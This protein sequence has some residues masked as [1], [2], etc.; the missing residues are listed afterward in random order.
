MRVSK[1]LYVADTKVCEL[2][3]T[4]CER[5]IPFQHAGV[6]E[7]VFLGTASSDQH[8][9]GVPGFP[10]KNRVVVVD[11][12]VPDIIL[13]VAEEEGISL[14]VVGLD[15]GEERSYLKSILKK[16]IDTSP[17]PLLIVSEKEGQGE[18]GLFDH[19]IFAT[20]WSGPSEK[21]LKYL[22]GFKDSMSTLEVVHVIHEKLTVR[23]IRQLKDRLVET[24]KVCLDEGIDAESHIYAGKTWEEIVRASQDYKGTLIT[25]GA[26]TKK[27]MWKELFTQSSILGVVSE[28]VVPVLVVP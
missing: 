22:L 11:D 4:V 19:I 9:E 21:A 26:S 28:A 5:L 24:R 12:L 15:K 10:V 18:K 13:R 14:I 6:Q 20:D 16:L 8:A 2:S 17:L 27:T 3:S 1:L 23:D 25:L 7:V